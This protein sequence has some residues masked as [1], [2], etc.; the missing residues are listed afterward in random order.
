MRQLTR[1]SSDAME[2]S[3]QYQTTQRQILVSVRPL[4]PRHRRCRVSLW[5]NV[6]VRCFR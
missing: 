3:K 4:V 2:L 1:V 5:H 6:P